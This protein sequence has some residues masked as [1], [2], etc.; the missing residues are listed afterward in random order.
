MKIVRVLTFVLL[1]LFFFP[2][3]AGK[4][5]HNFKEVLKPFRKALWMNDIERFEELARN[6]EDVNVQS[7]SNKYSILYSVLSGVHA[8][9]DIRFLEILLE[10]GADVHAK[11]LEGR[12]A[13]HNVARLGTPEHVR[14]LLRAGADI[15]ATDIYGRTMLSEA[16]INVR[17][18][19]F[20]EM[21]LDEAEADV[22]IPDEKGET[23]LHTFAKI[24]VG[25]GH[26]FLKRQI[27]EKLL[28][29][30]DAD[31][32]ARDNQG[33]TPLHHIMHWPDSEIITL[34]LK[35]GAD[36]MIS[37]EAGQDVYTLISKSEKLTARE[38]MT[39]LTMGIEVRCF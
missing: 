37:D 23:A 2:A 31:I 32:N 28:A 1:F 33:R 14:A 3:Q 6:I 35:N 8:S 18:V 13:L 21:L 24:Y 25:I 26:K 36:I 34:F 15:N 4:K 27:A 29:V 5:I 20:I 7:W 19:K 11:T 16:L 10:V 38:K 30:E 22:N 17:D 39:L 12:T 9:R